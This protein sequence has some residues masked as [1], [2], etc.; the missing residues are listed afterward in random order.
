MNATAIMVVAIICITVVGVFT[1]LALLAG[2]GGIEE[3]VVTA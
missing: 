3:G 1:A 2:A